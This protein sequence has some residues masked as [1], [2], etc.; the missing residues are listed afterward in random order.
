MS[1]EELKFT[2]K[3]LVE[4]LRTSRLATEASERMRGDLYNKKAELEGK[5]R[6]LENKL[7]DA[8]FRVS[9]RDAL[10]RSLEIQLAEE[11]ARAEAFEFVIRLQHGAP[12][13]SPEGEKRPHG[14]DAAVALQEAQ[15]Y[16]AGLRGGR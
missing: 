4:K 12:V 2:K 10:V 3:I 7:S 15:M 14:L 16:G 9:Q 8:E 5:I 1:D 11:D 13:V 6:D